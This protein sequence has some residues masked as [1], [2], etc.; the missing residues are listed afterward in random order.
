M[1]SKHSEMI[2]A[3]L[4]GILE[5]AAAHRAE[6]RKMS[7]VSA[8]IEAENRFYFRTLQWIILI[9][10]VTAGAAFVIAMIQLI[11]KLLS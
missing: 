9:A 7:A 11:V 3:N 8:K 4:T 2:Q 1:N 6:M 5:D 10:A